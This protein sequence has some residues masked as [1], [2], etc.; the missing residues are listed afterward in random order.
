MTKAEIAAIREG[1]GNAIKVN[2]NGKIDVLRREIEEHNKRHEQDMVRILPII[3]AYE[4]SERF[5]EDAK[6]NGKKAIMAVLWTGTFVTAVGGG[7]LIL[8]QLFHF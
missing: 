3:E 1:V 4:A 7:W 2:V 6:R 8:R 5:A